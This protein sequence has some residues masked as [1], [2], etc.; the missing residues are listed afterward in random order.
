MTSIWVATTIF[1]MSIE[2]NC[3]QEKATIKRWM[4]KRKW[5]WKC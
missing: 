1:G 3:L 4:G 2:L 5:K